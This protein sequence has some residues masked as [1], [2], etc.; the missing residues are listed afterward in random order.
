MPYTLA[1]KGGWR[2]AHLAARYALS[3]AR[4]LLR[5]SFAVRSPL[6]KL[7]AAAKSAARVKSCAAAAIRTR[8]LRRGYF[9]APAHDVGM[10]GFFA[11]TSH[12]KW[13]SAVLL[14]AVS[15]ALFHL[16]A[17]ATPPVS[18]EAELIHF[19][20]VLMRFLLPTVCFAV[21]V[22][23]YWNSAQ[24]QAARRARR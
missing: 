18:L 1:G 20:A 12:P 2:G 19:G 17:I 14:A 21:G 13:R 15:F 4:P 10:R 24:R 16:L 5:G 11:F 8:D 6:L 22:A 3:A 7:R 23:A 9:A